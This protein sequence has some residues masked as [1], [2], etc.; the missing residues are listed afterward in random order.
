MTI[1]FPCSIASKYLTNFN[2][3]KKRIK[4]NELGQMRKKSGIYLEFP[5]PS[6]SASFMN[7]VNSL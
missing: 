3:L 1:L 2:F 6:V 7:I 5:K 4:S